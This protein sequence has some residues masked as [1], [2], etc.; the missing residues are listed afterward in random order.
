MNGW[1]EVRSVRERLR[2]PPCWGPNEQGGMMVDME[3]GAYEADL[4]Q[5]LA[6]SGRMLHEVVSL[7][8]AKAEEWEAEHAASG[9]DADYGRYD[10]W[11][12][13]SRMVREI[14]GLDPGRP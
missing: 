5:L 9:S 12:N 2:R 13:A 4:D 8:D 10:A 7:L 11:E 1:S 3:V 14:A 6:A